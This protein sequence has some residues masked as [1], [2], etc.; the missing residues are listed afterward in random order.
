MI[1]YFK[2]NKEQIA[3]EITQMMGK[4]IVQSREELDCSIDRMHAL[5]GL[6]EEALAPEIV[7]KTS[8][9]T[10]SVIREPVK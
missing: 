8:N 4:P 3:T 2:T 9:I 10:K 5:I 6:A 7:S 1:T